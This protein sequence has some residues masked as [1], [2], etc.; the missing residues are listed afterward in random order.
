MGRTDGDRFELLER[1]GAGGTGSVYRARD[2][3]SG[4]FVAYKELHGFGPDDGARFARECALLATLS[5]PGIVRYVAH[6][7]GKQPWLAMEWVE[8]PTLSKVLKQR[9]LS[10][11][12]SLDV[13]R[14]VA[15]AVGALHQRGI[16]HRDVKPGNVILQ[17]GDPARPKLIDLGIARPEGESLTMTGVVV[18]TAGYMAPEQARGLSGIDARADVFALG[19]MLFRCL[20]GRAPFTGEDALSVMLRVTLEDAPKASEND[21][22]IPE[23]LDELCSRLLA[24]DRD[25]RPRDGIEVASLIA[26][27]GEVESVPSRRS[28]SDLGAVTTTERRL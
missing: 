1:V 23:E 3:L 21:S 18:G 12:E 2:R 28:F 16:V 8:G 19:S 26:D 22:R 9:G 10:W 13:T 15:G 17:D 7:F 11:T 14:K 24:R 5:A 20:T 27:L 25:L 6:G 4:D